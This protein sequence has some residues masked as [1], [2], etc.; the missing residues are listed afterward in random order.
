M[1]NLIEAKSP[2]FSRN[3][4][5]YL[6]IIVL[7]SFLIRFFY[8]PEGIPITHD[9]GVFFWY[10]NDLSMSGTFP[11]N[12]NI[13]NNGWPTFL[14]VFFSLFNSDNFLHYMDLQRYV[15]VI[16]SV[17]TIIPVFIL[18][19]KFC[20]TGLSLL[21]TIF[22]V[23]QPRVVENSLL[24]LSEPLFILLVLSCLVLFLQNNWKL[25]YMSFA[26]LALSCLV[27][28]E[29]IVLI[30]PLSFLFIFENRRD[31][32]IIPK[33]LIA[34]SIFLMVLLPMLFVRID[35]MGFDGI[36]SHSVYAV[37]V[38]TDAVT[39]TK[40]IHGDKAVF[41]L[42]QSTALA[43]FPIFFIFLPLGIFGFFRNRSFD[44]YVVL[45]FLIFLSL[46]IIYVSIR[47]MSEPRYFLALFPIF[48]LF[49][50]YTVKEIIRKFDK[51]KLISI[52]VGVT[53]LS[54]SIVYLD[55]TKIDYQHELDA[56]HIG[57]EIHKR[58]SVVNMYYPEEQYVHGRD[59]TFWNQGTFPV[60]SS[61]LER[62]V[63]TISVY[64]HAL[65][66]KEN[67][68]ESGCRQYDFPSLYEFINFGRNE[69]LTHIVADKNPNRA[70]F[71]ND[72][73]EN[74][75]KFSYLTKIYD[76]SEHGYEYHLKIFRIDYEKFETMI[77][78]DE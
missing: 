2:I 78:F 37:E 43:V 59:D 72:V 42:I 5:I 60:L 3:S 40:I 25:K 34:I 6:G 44:K 39:H 63:N 50:I 68:L 52:I 7:A 32:T 13:P 55:Y 69:G 73:F 31:K 49:S 38:Y 20:G 21:G 1:E 48:S 27:R 9:G 41:S 67:A 12:V 19:R 53:V 36:F 76:S 24:G 74:E 22:F 75:E 11:H 54:L 66:V 58:T 62:K 77:E 61:E 8:F 15:T 30:L 14:S 57:L 18:C 71:L 10:A 70:E 16:I 51:I 17:V 64:D 23:F 47:E 26:F 65:C 46:P 28:Y 35:T 56:Y 45:L 29:G 33:F 4:L